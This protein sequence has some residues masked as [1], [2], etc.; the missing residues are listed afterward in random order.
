MSE[1][2]K[3]LTLLAM[4]TAIAVVLITFVH[5]PL[6]PAAPFLQYDPS[7]CPSSSAPS[8]SARWPG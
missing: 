1:R 8:P 7:T 5:F 2:T 6:F 3:K 4:F